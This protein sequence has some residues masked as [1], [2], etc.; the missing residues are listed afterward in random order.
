MKNFLILFTVCLLTPFYTKSQPIT[1]E[2][3]YDYGWSEQSRCVQQT[4]DGGYIMAGTQLITMGASRNM[5]IKTDSAGNVSWFQ[6]WGTQDN[7]INSLKQTADSGFI[8]TGFK[9]GAQSGYYDITWI[10]TDNSGNVV[11]TKTLTPPLAGN[12][13]SS[14]GFGKDVL[15][16]PDSGFVILAVYGDSGALAPASILIKTNSYGDTLWTKK[17]I[18]PYPGN[19]CHQIQPTS[20]SGFIIVGQRAMNSI[21]PINITTYLIKTD[22]N[23][24]T[25]WTRNISDSLNEPGRNIEQLPSGNYIIKRTRAY[26]GSSSA[27]ISPDFLLTLADTNGTPIWTKSYGGLGGQEGFG[28]AVTSTGEF[29]LSGFTDNGSVCCDVYLVKTDSNGN[30]QWEKTFGSPGNTDDEGWYVIATSDGGFAVTG[31][32][33]NS[34]A[35]GTTDAYLIKTDSMGNVLT[36]IPELAEIKSPLLIYP[37]PFIDETVMLLPKWI[38]AEKNKWLV[39][40]DSKGSELHRQQIYDGDNGANIHRNGLAAGIYF[41]QVLS[42]NTLLGSSKIIIQ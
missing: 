6:L 3:W 7:E 39:I 14:A 33:Y 5:L 42:G 38:A 26:L 21:P 2:K 40:T 4:F 35:P 24:D 28:L 19:V 10:K 23:G 9:T 22:A 34:A 13:P 29:L 31:Y 1:F 11:W 15:Q 18:T 8:M 30:Q 37:N 12:P 36:A 20:D 27:N 32:R 17:Y 16:T 41:V 25:L